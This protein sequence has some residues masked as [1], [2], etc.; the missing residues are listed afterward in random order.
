MFVSISNATIAELLSR[1]A[2]EA[3][4][5]LRRALKGAACQ[6]LLWPDETNPR[7]LRDVQDDLQM[8]TVWSEVS[9]TIA[10]MGGQR[11]ART[12]ST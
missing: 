1:E 8:L 3:N 7:W 12:R 2:E 6:A 4:G 11:V 10:D 9:G 5:H